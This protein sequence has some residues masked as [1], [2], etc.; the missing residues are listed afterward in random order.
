MPYCQKRSPSP[1]AA[2][3][4]VG[5]ATGSLPRHHSKMARRPLQG[6]P[7]ESTWV[8]EQLS[9]ALRVHHGQLWE[10]DV[11][12]DADPQATG[13]CV[14]HS[15]SAARSQRLGLLEGDAAP[16]CL[17]RTGA[18]AHEHQWHQSR[19]PV[20]RNVELRAAAMAIAHAQFRQPAPATTT[21][22]VS[23]RCIWTCTTCSESA[24]PFN[25]C[26]ALLIG[27]RQL[28]S[29]L[30]DQGTQVQKQ[31]ADYSLNF[32]LVTASLALGQGTR[33]ELLCCV[34]G[35]APPLGTRQNTMCHNGCTCSREA[36][37]SVLRQEPAL[38]AE[39]EAGVVQLPL[40][41]LWNRAAHQGDCMAPGRLCQGSCARGGPCIDVLSIAGEGVI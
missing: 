39:D 13:I 36:H 15:A 4:C 7:E 29:D 34:Y 24:S 40:A 28:R 33:L 21:V 17:C 3:S 30:A 5:S 12:A 18:P 11:I 19:T 6:A 35:F 37:L 41:A 20:W 38:L 22:A 23:G 25:S 31:G 9:A 32:R 8:H 27:L 16:G 1:P 2:L 14:H 10:S 26:P